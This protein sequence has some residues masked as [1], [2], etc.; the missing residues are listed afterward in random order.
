[1][2]NGV[3]KITALYN[4]FLL[5]CAHIFYNVRGRFTHKNKTF[6]GSLTL[7]IVKYIKKS[8]PR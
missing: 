7:Y 4:N 6:L 3:E 5:C 2:L 8:V 1:M